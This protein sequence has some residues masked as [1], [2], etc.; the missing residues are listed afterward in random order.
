MAWLL[1]RLQAGPCR[2]VIT[3]AWPEEGKSTV[4]LALAQQLASLRSK[5]VLLIDGDLRNPTLS[6]RMELKQEGLADLARGSVPA[7]ARL[8]ADHPLFGLGAG[9]AGVNATETV[10]AVMQSGLLPQCFQ[11]FDL[12]LMDSPPLTACEDALLWGGQCDGVIL[13]ISAK[14]YRGA[15]KLELGAFRER[16]VPILGAVLTREKRR[17]RWGRLLT[18]L[19]LRS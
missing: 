11:G 14:Q 10:H 12:V 1:H 2:L 16:G 4:A 7:A 3:S 13:V 17:S 6:H 18:S 15:D 9:D 5:S 19:G 8:D